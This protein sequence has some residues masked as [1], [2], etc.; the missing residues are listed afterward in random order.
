MNSLWELEN[1][2]SMNGLTSQ[3]QTVD[4]YKIESALRV[5]T[6]EFNRLMI[7]E[8]TLITV[9][10]QLSDLEF[11][12][13]EILEIMR[14]MGRDYPEIVLAKPELFTQKEIIYDA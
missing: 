12:Y 14:R 6:N 7:V 4:A 8:T 11:K 10:S 1:E 13:A 9:Q 2:L 3:V 5:I